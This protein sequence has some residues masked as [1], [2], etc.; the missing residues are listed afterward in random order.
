[1]YRELIFVLKFQIQISHWRINIFQIFEFS[2]TSRDHSLVESTIKDNFKITFDVCEF[3]SKSHRSK[4]DIA[5]TDRLKKHVLRGDECA[6]WHKHSDIQTDIQ[7]DKQ[8]LA[9]YLYWL[10]IVKKERYVIY[11]TYHSII[12]LF[13]NIS[14][15]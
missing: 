13:S 2:P 12:I 15:F 6:K 3:V 8:T 4:N 11:Y 14:Y 5:S 9:L 1:M 10:M 7:T